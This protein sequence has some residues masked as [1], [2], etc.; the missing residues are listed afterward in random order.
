M[1]VRRV[2][3]G[4]AGPPM[5]LLPP[6]LPDSRGNRLAEYEVRQDRQTGQRRIYLCGPEE[7]AEQLRTFARCAPMPMTRAQS[8]QWTHRLSHDGPVSGRVRDALDQFK[9]VLVL[10]VRQPI[11]TG[12]A[13]DFY[14]DPS[15][16]HDPMQ[17]SDT[18]A[19]SLIYRGKY[20]GNTAAE[21]ELAERLARVI[22]RHPTYAAADYVLVVPGHDQTR[23]SFG[24]RLATTVA[25]LVNKP[26]VRV[27]ALN[28]QRAQAKARQPGDPA[29]ADEFEVGDEV[30]GRVLI[31]V[32]DVWGHGDTMGAI[33]GKA[34]SAGANA[35]LALVGARR[36]RS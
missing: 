34:K 10:R 8:R 23:V 28:L 25:G 13:L 35:F 31:A 16:H 19:G 20:C 36:M 1:F 24:E 32:D 21:Q 2:T 3:T 18:Y 33:A 11:D 4:Y 6:F 14:K 29:L 7:V 9:E 27:R 22:E 12:I 17:W 30:A 15:S 26:V 5:I